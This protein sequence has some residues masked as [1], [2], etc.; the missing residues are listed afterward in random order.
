MSYITGKN[1]TNKILELMSLIGLMMLPGCSS[2]DTDEPASVTDLPIEV[3]SSVSNL[4]DA[5]LIQDTRGGSTSLTRAWTPPKNYSRSDE[6]KSISIIFTK[7]EMDGLEDTEKKKLQGKFFKSSGHWRTTVDITMAGTYYLY[8][9]MPDIVGVDYTISKP[10]GDGE[11][12]KDGAVMVLDKLPTVTSEDLC[13]VVGAKNGKDDYKADADYS[14]TGLQ[15]GSFDYV[16]STTTGEGSGGN[17]VYLLFD[18]IYASLRLNFRV[19]SKYN[20]LRTIKIKEMALTTID[21]SD[22]SEGSDNKKLTKATITLTKTT[23][24]ADP[25]VSV[26]FDPSNK[27]GYGN[28][29]TSEDGIELTNEYKTFMSY[30]MPNGITKLVLATVYDVYDKQG[31]LIRKDCK[32]KNTIDLKK[33]IDRFESVQR[34]TRYTFNLTINPT[35]L[36]QLSEPDLNDPE[37]VLE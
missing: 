27:G 34:G 36:Y 21:K 8:G 31:N 24:G 32:A 10:T 5:A 19:E 16:A 11:D 4:E 17:Y 18:H 22:T 33:L 20:A 6:D 29:L 35:Y 12:Y 26:D 9:Y 37:V 13:V 30:F 14:V 25:I 23:G 7:N 3:M 1:I 2:E 15:R 28:I